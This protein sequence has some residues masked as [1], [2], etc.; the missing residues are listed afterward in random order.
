MYSTLCSTKRIKALFSLSIT[1]FIHAKAKEQ[2]NFYFIFAFVVF[3]ARF[4]FSSFIFLYI[5]IQIKWN[6][7]WI[8]GWFQD[9]MN[10]EIWM[11]NKSTSFFSLFFVLTSNEIILYAIFF[12]CSWIFCNIIQNKMYS[13][14]I[15][16][17]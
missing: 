2:H 4:L 13:I 16:C 11:W 12:F 14:C 8:V 3:T 1:I 17:V 10:T 7:R 6:R 5:Y 15:V 9:N